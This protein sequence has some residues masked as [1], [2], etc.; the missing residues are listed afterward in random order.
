[1]QLMLGSMMVQH[2]AAMARHATRHG[3]RSAAGSHARAQ[4]HAAESAAAAIEDDRMDGGIVADV[5]T[6]TGLGT[7]VTLVLLRRIAQLR[8]VAVLQRLAQHLLAQAAAADGR[9]SGSGSPMR[10]RIP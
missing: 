2:G 3:C 1:M 7:N 4:S 8:I 5:L 6:R 9:V 10:G